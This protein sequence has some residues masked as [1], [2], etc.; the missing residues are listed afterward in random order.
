[1]TVVL[2]KKKSNPRLN[3]ENQWQENIGEEAEWLPHSSKIQTGKT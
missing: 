3:V 2:K 1:M